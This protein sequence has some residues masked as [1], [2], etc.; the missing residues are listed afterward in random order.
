MNG[1]KLV[2]DEVRRA[3]Y[4]VKQMREVMRRNA[5][6]HQ[7]LMA[8]LVHSGEKKKVR[9][10]SGVKDR[11]KDEEREREVM[12]ALCEQEADKLAKEVTEKLEEAEEQCRESLQAEW[13]ECR[14]C[15]EDAC[16]NFYTSTCRRGFATFHTKAGSCV[17]LSDGGV[18][19][20]SKLPINDLHV[21]VFCR[22]LFLL[23]LRTF[24]AE[25]PAAL[26]TASVVLTEGTFWSTRT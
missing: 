5:Q 23:R 9:A 21:T 19:Y 15:L 12:S 26:A 17:L 18:C 14:P 2:D 16:K 10:G 20:L 22:F 11:R 1:E 4:G 8:S 3:L 13:E 7:Q 25:S 6:K 24:S